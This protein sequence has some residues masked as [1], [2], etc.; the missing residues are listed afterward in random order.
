M[1]AAPDTT[2]SGSAASGRST[3]NN[4]GGRGGGNRTRGSRGGQ[5]RAI[6][7]TNGQQAAPN[8]NRAV[9]KGNT[10]GMCGHVFECYEEQDDRRQYSKTIEALNAYVKKTLP[11]TADLASLFAATITA[12]NI[13]RPDIIDDDADKLDSHHDFCGRSKR[14]REAY[15][16][17]EE[18]PGNDLC[19]R[20]GTMQQCYE[21]TCEDAQR[22]RG[23]VL[24]KQLR[25]AT[26]KC[27]QQTTASGFSGF[28]ASGSWVRS[29]L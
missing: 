2:T 14:V 25:L 9:F 23:N 27:P 21:G 20:V 24:N 29:G 3:N 15:K 13:D 8:R 17:P 5:Q 26:R 1:S 22:L 7:S 18:Q 11:Y 4:S 28:F 6:V 10:E 19:R 12:P 16:N